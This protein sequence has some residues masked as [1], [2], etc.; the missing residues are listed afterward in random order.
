MSYDYI[1]KYIL[2][3]DPS[4]G[5]S[6]ILNRLMNDTFNENYDVTVGVEFG[7]KIINVWDKKIKL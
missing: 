1:F 5:K 6:C 7:T 3:G 4:V 2:I